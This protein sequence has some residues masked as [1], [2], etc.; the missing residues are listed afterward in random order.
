MHP[1]KIVQSKLRRRLA[2]PASELG[3]HYFL[4]HLAKTH[5][6]TNIVDLLYSFLQKLNIILNKKVVSNGN[7]KFGSGRDKRY[8]VFNMIAIHSTKK[9]LHKH[10]YY[11]ISY[12]IFE[13]K[14]NN[15]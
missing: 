15:K 11:L 10:L 1:K 6:F 3:L 4:F 8:S 7:F 13:R 14:D 9:V 12:S 5:K 2:E